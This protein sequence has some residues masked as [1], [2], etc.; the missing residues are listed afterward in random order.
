MLIDTPGLREMGNMDVEN[1]IET[2]FATIERHAGG[3]LFNDCTH[4][5]EKGCAVE[6][7]LANGLL[8]KDRYDHYLKLKKESDYYRLSYLEKRKKDRKLG[9]LYRSI[10]KNKHKHQ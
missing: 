4:T 8:E 7:A 10:M 5:G 3:C 2:V 9:K 1:G 6:E